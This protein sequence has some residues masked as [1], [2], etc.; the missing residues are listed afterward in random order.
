[1]CRC[2][3]YHGLARSSDREGMDAFGTIPDQISKI[4]DF[5]A[6]RIGR[7]ERVTPAEVEATEYYEYPMIT[8]REIVANALVHRNYEDEQRHVHV[9]VFSDRI[10]VGSPGTWIGEPLP[11][12]GSSRQLNELISESIARNKRL[13]NIMA[14]SPLVEGEGSGLPKSVEECRQA[15]IPIPIVKHD[16]GFVV[17]T[18]FPNPDWTQERD[19]RRRDVASEST[20]NFRIFISAVTSEFGGARDALAADLR[21]WDT[22]V[23][24]QSDF[25]QEAD[26]A[27]T[28]KKLHD[29]IRDCSAVICIIGR[30]S[31]ACPPPSLAAPFARMLP[32]GIIE[33]SYAQWEFFFARHYRRRLSL[34]FAE[35]DNQ[36]DN[37][38]PTGDD[39]PDLQKAFVAHI[40]E[41]QGLDRSYFSNVDQLARAVLKEDWPRKPPVKPIVLPYASLGRLFK[42][43]EAL[44]RRLHESLTRGADGGLAVVAT[45]LY[46]LGGIGK[47]RAAVEYAW[48]YHE[49]YTAVLFAQAASS[50]ELRRNLASLGGPLL[51]PERETAEEEV[52]LNAVLAWLAANPGWLLILD[53]LDDPAA[54]AEVDRLMGRLAGG[55]V[56]LTSRNDRFAR[57]VEALELDVLTPDAAAAFLLE[58]TEGRRDKAADDDAA[59]R[60]LAEELGR[61]ALA[62]EQAAAT[63][64]KL[65][66]S[67]RRYLEIWRG[68]RER[69][70]GWARP[71][72]TGYHNAV[73]AAWQTSVDQ[74]SEAGRHLLERLAFLA[75]DP[76]P[77]FLLDVAVPGAEPEDQ[78]DALADLAAVSLAAPEAEGERFVVHRLVQDVTR[79]SLDTATSQRRVTEALGWVNAA[80]EGNPQDVRTWPRLDPLAPHA[81]AVACHADAAGIL[82]PTARLM[83]QLGLLFG[84]KALFAEAEPLIRR[85]VAIEEKSFGPD[86]H[87]IARNL[88][89]LGQLLLATN[90]VAEAEPLIRRALAIDEKSFEP[91]HP[92]IARNLA[93]LGQ[94]LLATN[95][96]TEAEPLYRRALT[97]SEK[98]FGPDHPNVAAGL[99]NLAE[100]LRETNRHAEAEPLMRRALTI[101]GASFG[102]DHPTVAIRL[103]NLAG[104]LQHTNRLAEAEP[105]YRR[106]LEIDE[107]S[108][109]PDHP[110]VATNLNNLAGLL[111]ATNRHAE[112]EP[113]MRRAL[114]IDEA[115]FGADHLDVARDLNNLA[116]L[117]RATN[118]LAEAEPLMRRMVSI[119]IDFEHKTGHQHPHHGAVT[120]DYTRLL[121]AM[122]M[123]E[124]EITEAFASLTAE[125]GT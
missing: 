8:L 23:R 67:F 72:I 84:T 58:A 121:A 57:Q 124:A 9:R 20:G 61:L 109:G 10:E 38:K 41:E 76:V 28:L 16:K 25:R 78:Q 11:E 75:P 52:R 51:L 68:T 104:L 94:L 115:S 46:G 43:R 70:V 7:R 86:H 100:L 74:L 73:A 77:M 120:V 90:R 105:L 3:V 102:T 101:D 29:Y 59:A 53:N 71:E 103:N 15:G 69:V 110:A 2:S 44:L 32:E 13:A 117:L 37:D 54:L 50:E 49:D 24:V 95:R 85:A 88:N 119:F 93:N 99:N 22:L 14:W 21:S 80:F 116:L 40:V 97:I 56:L 39:F 65:R 35:P 111:R 12:D 106:A 66:C 79:R 1:M 89:N 108:F 27:N 62:L 98:S 36:P 4:R 17:V 30:R 83:N 82:E 6:T 81:Q 118:R 122:G 19:I 125:G 64:E 55:H 18:V 92:N 123:G 33:A 48:A 45:A 26:A 63:I 60:E 107:A 91:D 87:N 31:G 113:L 47:T 112:A 5:I 42:G 34:Y 114:A 96:L